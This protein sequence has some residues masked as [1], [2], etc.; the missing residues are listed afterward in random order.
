MKDE[1][2]V[3]FIRFLSDPE[4]GTTAET[5]AQAAFVLAIICVGAP[6]PSKP[7]GSCD[8]AHQVEIP[9]PPPLSPPFPQDVTLV[10]WGCT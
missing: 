5:R 10:K 2:H 9:P 8:P 1:G 6:Q 4:E 3:Y 7:P